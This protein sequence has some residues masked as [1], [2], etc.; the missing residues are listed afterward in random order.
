MKL[1]IIVYRHIP[2]VSANTDI[3]YVIGDEL[4]KQYQIVYIGRKQDECQ[5][6]INEYNGNRIIFLNKQCG[7]FS[8]LQ[9]YLARFDFMRIAYWKEIIALSNIVEREKIDAILCITAPNENL[10]I[11]MSAGIKVPI[12][13]YQ[14]DPFF[15][16][17]D[18]DDIRLK[19]L[20]LRYVERCNHLFTT[21]L[22]MNSYQ[23]DDCFNPYIDKISIINFPKLRQR[24][25]EC[26]NKGKITLLYAGSLY[27][28][29]KPSILIEL[30]YCLSTDFE[31]VFCGKCENN[32]D[33][34]ELEEHGI[35]CRGYC[36]QEALE[37]ALSRADVF[38]N[39]GNIA[40]N[41]MPSKVIDYI[42]TGKPIVNIFQIEGCSSKRF[43]A[44]YE[45]V[46]NVNVNNISDNKESI[47]NFVSNSRKRIIPWKDIRL[48]FGSYTPEYVASEIMKI[49]N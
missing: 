37:N 19:R 4:S 25:N 41:Q 20:F 18:I 26:H 47:M 22:L 23:E 34:K 49:I 8:I 2:Y 38:I 28:E 15:N 9:N 10:Y 36:D 45:N 40:R 42:S 35:Q 12:Y 29:R 13:I 3:A 14:L 31:I 30:K 6:D 33:E 39:I 44:N 21:D 24:K 17:G 43:L 7:E 1:G 5:N 32:K 16:H 46:L 27:A 11:T 48:K